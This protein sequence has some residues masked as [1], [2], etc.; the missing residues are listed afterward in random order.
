MRKNRFHKIIAIVIL[1]ILQAQA[2]AQHNFRYSASLDTVPHDGFYQVNLQPSLTAQLMRDFT[3]IRILDPAGKQVPYIAQRD[4]V[5]FTNNKFTAFPIISNR[6]E[7]D[8]QVHV[9]I[10][11]ISRRP[12][13]EL[14]VMFK[15]AEANRILT[16]SGSDDN[17]QWY[18]VKEHVYFTSFVSDSSDEFTQAL[19]F[20]KSNYRYFRITMAG[21]DILPVNIVKAGIYEEQIINGKFLPLPAVSLLQKDSGDKYSYI[22]IRL[23]DHHFIDRIQIEVKGSRYYK[24]T[25]TVYSGPVQHPVEEGVFVL[26]PIESPIYP[27][28]TKADHL[29]LKIQ[30]NDN[31]PLEIAAV[32]CYQ[33]SLCLQAYLNQGKSYH[34][35]WGDSSI[36]GADY[37]LA[38]FKDSITNISPL[39]YN[40][41]QRNK[42]LPKQESPAGNNKMW[43]WLAIAAVSIVLL[44]LTYSLTREMKKRNNDR[45]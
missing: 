18:V 11:N 39:G 21:K 4:T 45:L 34:L 7:A 30:N 28:D 35:V 40:N 8:K 9:V 36:A 1:C 31:P 23:N 26:S 5:V 32:T 41:V 25:M 17:S 20:P 16:I 27:L 37:D 42:L 2:Y 38:A 3:D 15:N 6:R 22:F 33:Q 12:L 24:R 14:I 19:T 29:L 43:V 13:S 10:E 44:I